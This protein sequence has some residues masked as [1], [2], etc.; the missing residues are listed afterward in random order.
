MPYKVFLSYSWSNSAERHALAKAISEIPNV[1][2][3]VDKEFIQPGD[4][5]HDSISNAIDDADCLVVLLTREGLK[6]REV[7]DEIGRAHERKKLIIPVVAEKTPLEK[8]P[9]YLRDLNWITYGD[10]NFDQVLEAIMKTISRRANPL[11]GIDLR[12]MPSTLVNAIQA[13]ARFLDVP[14]SSESGGYKT[15]FADE[16]LFCRLK[17]RQ[18]EAQFVLRV[19]KAMRIKDAAEFLAYELLPHLYSQDYEWLLVHYE[20][21]LPGSHTFAT[22]T[23]QD[24]D[25]VYLLGN[26]REPMWAPCPAR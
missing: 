4:S 8:L 2:P 12:K 14:P 10:R 20:R 6:S 25:T 17:M 26:H 11:E 9:W 5:V 21:P 22:T 18:T 3:L 19:S 13:G 1:M 7:L 15:S 23:I 16:Y 24:G